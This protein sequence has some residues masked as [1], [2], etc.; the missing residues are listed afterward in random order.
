MI[1][2]ILCVK[3]TTDFKSKVKE[4]DLNKMLYFKV[5][6]Y[7]SIF[8]ATNHPSAQSRAPQDEL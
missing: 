4:K 6:F 3:K 8:S 5:F 1:F 7:N 2:L